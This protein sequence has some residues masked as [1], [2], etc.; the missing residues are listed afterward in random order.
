MGNG[1]D[2]GWNSARYCRA[3]RQRHDGL[4]YVD[5]VDFGINL[6]SF[7]YVLRLAKTLGREK[8]KG[9]KTGNK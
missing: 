3:D 5:V 9:T 1:L 6:N 2:V 4:S 8:V 7:Q